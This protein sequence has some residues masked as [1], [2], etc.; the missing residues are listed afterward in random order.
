MA[1]NAHGPWF[2]SV[3]WITAVLLWYRK[4]QPA[5]G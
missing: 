3:D 5:L 2:K 1:A 4:L